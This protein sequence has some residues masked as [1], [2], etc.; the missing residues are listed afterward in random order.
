MNLYSKLYDEQKM[1]RSHWIHSQTHLH[2]HTHRT[3][4]NQ[5]K[6]NIIITEWIITIIKMIKIACSRVFKMKWNMKINKSEKQTNYNE[7]K[8]NCN[9]VFHF[10][11]VYAMADG[12]FYIILYTNY[13]TGSSSFDDEDTFL[14]LLL[15]IPSASWSCT[16]RFNSDRYFGFLHNFY[17]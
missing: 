15:D 16:N 5:Q 10:S 1:N 6:K 3:K 17:L 13:P 4:E 7:I 14:S 2:L 12:V 8:I 9:S 11:E